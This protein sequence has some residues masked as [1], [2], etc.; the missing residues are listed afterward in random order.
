MTTT[1]VRITDSRTL[2]E[3]QELMER[4]DELARKECRSRTNMMRMLLME[5]L[6]ARE[7]GE[8]K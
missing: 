5:A 1:P 6:E 4:V 8:S 2:R 3:D 7:A